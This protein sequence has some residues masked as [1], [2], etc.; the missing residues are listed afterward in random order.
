MAG[1][2]GVSCTRH[3]VAYLPSVS[4][5]IQPL[6]S[7][8]PSTAILAAVGGGHEGALPVTHCTCLPSGGQKG[9]ILY[10]EMTPLLFFLPFFRCANTLTYLLLTMTTILQYYLSF[11]ILKGK[12]EK[13]SEVQKNWHVVNH[14][15]SDRDC[16]IEVFFTAR[17]LRHR[18]CFLFFSFF[19]LMIFR[20]RF[21]T[22]TTVKDISWLWQFWF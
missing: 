3:G 13:Y 4:S 12:V 21:V 14:K 22:M 17:L 16:V 18:Y 15:L 9:L 19:F 20:Q 10:W 8:L 1:R 2:Q 7:T 6:H 5:S 11:T